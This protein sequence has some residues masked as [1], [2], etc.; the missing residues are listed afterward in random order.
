M[1]FYDFYAEHICRN[2]P[3]SGQSVMKH[4]CYQAR[5]MRATRLIGDGTFPLPPGTPIPVYPVDAFEKAPKAW[6]KGA[7]SYVCPVEPDWG[8]WFDWTMNAS[9]DTAV[10]PSVKGMNPITGQKIEGLG[11]ERYEKKCPVHDVE[12]VGDDYYC[13]ECGYNWPPQ[14]Y[15]CHPNTLWWD[16]FRSADGT[17]RQF[18]FSQDDEKDIASA[19]IG[20]KNVVPAFGF[21]FYRAKKSRQPKGG[22]TRSVEFFANGSLSV[23]YSLSSSAPQAW[24]YPTK[25]IVTPEYASTKGVENYDYTVT[26]DCAPV[27]SSSFCHSG[28]VKT[29]GGIAGPPVAEA[30][31][32]GAEDDDSV[33]AQSIYLN[34]NK[35][36]TGSDQTRFL[37]DHGVR[38][39][40]E[41]S[42][43]SIAKAKRAAKQS[44]EEK[45]VAVGGGAKIEQEL[46]VDTMDKVTDWKK[47]P[48]GIIR[49]YFCFEPEFAKLVK[50]GVRKL[51]GEKEGYLKGL[52]VG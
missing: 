24:T 12:F 19:V 14:N 31:V 23:N 27:A 20:K 43:Q 35:C 50:G 4:K 47:R 46:K 10:I 30:P 17:V 32:A 45:K 28:E 1:E 21:C 34:Q 25:G 37:K 9:H 2:T 22:S 44:L 18:F 41:P 6:V 7:G 11:L 26:S 3:L 52:P 16:G 5:L 39:G 38:C 48:G 29:S 8:L 42:P 13:E 36:S 33:E 49:L 15:V 40:S 51:K